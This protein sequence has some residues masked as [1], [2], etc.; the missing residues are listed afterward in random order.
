MCV[1]VCVCVCVGG[2]VGVS[3]QCMLSKYVLRG[4]QDPYF[5]SEIRTYYQYWLTLCT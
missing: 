1:R 4:T 2:W 5:L 3:S